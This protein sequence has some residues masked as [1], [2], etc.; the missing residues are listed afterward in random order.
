[1]DIMNFIGSVLKGQIIGRIEED[2]DKRHDID[3]WLG[4]FRSDMVNYLLA[5]DR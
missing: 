2:W 5:G 4:S 1:M 3:G